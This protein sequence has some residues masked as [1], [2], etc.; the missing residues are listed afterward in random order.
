MKRDKNKLLATVIGIIVVLIIFIA[1]TIWM[2]HS[3][4]EDTDKAIRTVSTLYLDELAGRREQ[5]VASNLQ[6]NM[7]TIR[8][9]VD[10]MTEEDLSDDAHRQAYQQRMKALYQ[11][12]RFAFVGESGTIY[13]STG[14]S[15]WGSE[16]AFD[17]RNMTEPDIS[18]KNLE[19][20]EKKV[21]IAVPISPKKFKDDTLI[22]CFMEIDM[23]QML[24]GISMSSNKSDATFCNL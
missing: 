1:G 24:H 10:L 18:V 4:Q 8:I 22:V 9:A 2:G 14:T 19:S 15:D 20:D 7:E 13:L 16:Y 23:Q 5:V 11:L 12:D 17:Y 21:V 6:D 3:A